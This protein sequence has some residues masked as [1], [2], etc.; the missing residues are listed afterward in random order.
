MVPPFVVAPVTTKFKPAP[1]SVSELAPFTVSEL[2]FT[3]AVGAATAW[4]I[5]TSAP[6]V[7][8]LRARQV[9]PEAVEEAP[10]LIVMVVA[11][12]AVTVELALNCASA[13]VTSTSP[14]E[15][16]AVGSALQL[17]V[18]ETAVVLTVKGRSLAV[19]HVAGVFQADA[20]LV[21]YVCAKVSSL[22]NKKPRSKTNL[23]VFILFIMHD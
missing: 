14:T 15:I 18:V 10:V 11:E 9:T 5:F 8:T 2:M 22:V 21:L 1:L 23:N 7:G 12:T 19:I 13:E 16:Y 20:A 4:E 6:A 3:E 17:T